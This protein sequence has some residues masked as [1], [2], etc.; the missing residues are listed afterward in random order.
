MIP[1]GAPFGLCGS[2]CKPSD[3][4]V[5][6]ESKTDAG[7]DCGMYTCFVDLHIGKSDRCWHSTSDHVNKWRFSTAPLTGVVASDSS[8]ILDHFHVNLS[9]R[10]SKNVI[11][12]ALSN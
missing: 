6:P 7:H 1:I 11:K 2:D 10:Y 3:D 12:T 5:C 8:S 4:G 9:K